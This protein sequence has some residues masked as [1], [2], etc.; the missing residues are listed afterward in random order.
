MIP[1]RVLGPTLSLLLATTGTSTT[2]VVELIT[3][4]PGPELYSYWG[5][6]ALRIIDPQ[7]GSDRVYNF[8]SVDFS[9]G[10]F[11]RMMRGQVDAFIGV[12]TYP[13]TE[14]AYVGEDRT[15]ERRTLALTASAASA[16][17]Q[18]L[19]Q[20]HGP[21]ATYRYHHFLDN[22]STRVAVLLDQAS[23]GQLRD[24]RPET[25]TATFRARA[26]AQL[27]PHPFTAAAVDLCL[28]HGVD[29]PISRFEATFLPD[30]LAAQLDQRP[31]LVLAR[32]QVHQAPPIRPY[33]P[34]WVIAASVTLPLLLLLAFRPRWGLLIY[35]IGAG[36]LGTALLLLW[37]GTT[38][39]FVARNLNLLV[40]PPTHLLWPFLRPDRQRAYGSLH[41]V[42]LLALLGASWAGAVEQDVSGPLSLGLA[43]TAGVWLRVFTSTE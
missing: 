7:D 33:R 4:G 22:C 1:F 32:T 34:W 17:S 26:L 12:S 21:K 19:R 40:L 23:G 6:A 38:Y 5:H 3:M 11:V 25:P 28:A 42:I 39:D 9:D 24:D 13:R 35:G 15:F 10:F 43:L 8:G 16:L 41:L 30:A 18:T 37:L 29:R 2:P 31:G 27:A 36:V 20:N 14:A